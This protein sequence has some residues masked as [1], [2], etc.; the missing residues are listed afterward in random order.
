MPLIIAGSGLVA[1]GYCN[2]AKKTVKE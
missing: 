2:P 1:Q